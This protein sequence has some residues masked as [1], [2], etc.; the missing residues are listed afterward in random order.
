MGT[1]FCHIWLLAP[2]P[3]KK[4]MSTYKTILIYICELWPGITGS[5]L[6][7]YRMNDQC[8]VPGSGRNFYLSPPHPD[9]LCGLPSLLPYRVPGALSP[10]VEWLKCKAIYP[11]PHT[12]FMVWCLST[13]TT[14][15]L[16]YI[17]ELTHLIE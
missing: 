3:R 11:L 17:C 12:V 2:F 8:F 15:P 13:G 10:G 6:T 7:G 1:L 9:Q 16:L 14:L 5:K 4:P